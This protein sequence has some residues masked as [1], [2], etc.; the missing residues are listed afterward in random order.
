MQRDAKEIL[1]T[2]AKVFGDSCTLPQLQ[3][4]LYGYK[5][6]DGEDLAACSLEIVRLF[7][8]ITE[9]DPSF[10]Q[11]RK[12][13]LNSRIAEA[14]SND[15]MRMELRRLA[16]DHPDLSFFD[17]RDHVLEL[18]GRR[19]KIK[20]R[21][22]VTMQEVN[23]AGNGMQDALK[24]QAEQIAAPQKQ[25]QSLLTLVSKPVQSAAQRCPF[26]NNGPRRCWNCNQLGHL[27]WDC[28]LQG[29]KPDA[30]TQAPPQTNS[31]NPSQS[32]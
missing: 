2:L 14:V 16:S 19:E 3:Q 5:Q 8:R 20:A 29:S 12:A 1:K 7:D 22:D 32:N 24:Q 25:I 10:V 17:T 6:G 30:P 9:M 31:T 15:G 21:R 26:I 18:M 4:H 13:Q 11:S 28:P 23:A 27:K